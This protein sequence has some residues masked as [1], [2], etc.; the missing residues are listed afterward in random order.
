LKINLKDRHFIEVT[1]TESRAA[2]NTLTEC[3][4]QDAFKMSE[5]LGT[6]KTEKRTTRWV[7]VASRSKVSF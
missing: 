7:M 2:L 5:A 4:F 1:E 6:V 3:D